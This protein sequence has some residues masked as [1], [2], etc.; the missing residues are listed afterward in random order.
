LTENSQEWQSIRGKKWLVIAISVLILAPCWW[1]RHIEAGDLGSHVYNAWLAQLIEK[2][3]A[4]G[5]YFA[6]QWNNVL[7]DWMLL[8]AADLVGFAAGEKIV[9]S[10]CVLVFFWG[11]FA[12]VMASAERAPWF[13]APCIAMLAYGYAFNMGF[14]NYYLS[15]GLAAL[16]LALL[17]RGK[18]IGRIAGVILLP[19]VLLAHPLGMLWLVGTA[20]YIFLWDKLPG[21]WKLLIPLAAVC[22]LLAI[23]WYLDYKPEFA[24]DWE[25]P[26][27]YVLN[28]ADQVVLYSRR[29]AFVAAAAVLLGVVCTAVDAF[30]RTR[31]A[32]FWRSVR[33]PLGLYAVAL[34]TTALLPQ[35][36]KP[37]ATGGLI[38]LLDSRL[39]AITAILGL[40]VLNQM[41]PRKFALAGFAACA[42]VFFALLY[43]DT[44]VLNRMESN[45]ESMVHELPFG[46]K[47][48]TTIWAP[49]GS[50]IWFMS[51]LADRACIEHCFSFSNYEPSTEQF[52]VRARPGNA[53]VTAS[54]DDSGEMQSGE[55]EVQDEDLPMKEIYQ[56]DVKDLTKL[57]IRDLAAGELNGRLGYKPP[58]D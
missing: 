55:Y 44:Q 10:L 25:R 13:L 20:A 50:H 22:A 9:V 35:N 24:A 6:P 29:Y 58:A 16:S 31:D 53:I 56:C 5:L 40:C 34:M 2:G 19:L 30:P 17:W 51:H 39:T 18:G 8:H 43:Q 1:H 33:L 45:V 32:A 36:L 49:P 28:G 38:G 3:Q 37:S 15:L 12:F 48:L 54:Y 47:V 26:A 11:V 46:T 27:F 4:P 41:R 23:H 57:C 7:V 21:W 14:L 42:V 52:R